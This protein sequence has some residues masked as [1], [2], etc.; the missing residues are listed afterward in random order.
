M[1]AVARRPTNSGAPSRARSGSDRPW[2]SSG[3]TTSDSRRA[4]RQRWQAGLARGGD[5]D[6]GDRAARF[7][8]AGSIV[9]GSGDPGA[10]GHHP[11][12]TVGPEDGARALVHGERGRQRR[13]RS[14]CHGDVRPLAAGRQ[15]DLDHERRGL[16]ARSPIATGDRAGGRVQ[17]ATARGDEGSFVQPRVRRCVARRPVHRA[18]GVRRR[19]PPQRDLRRPLLRRRRPPGRERELA[20]RVHR[21]SRSSRPTERGS[22]SSGPGPGSAPRGPGRSSR[23]TSTGRTSVASRHGVV[24]SWIKGGRPTASGSCTSAPTGCSRWCARMAATRMTS[25]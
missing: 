7:R 9:G 23:S 11:V 24:R 3:S 20:R 4:R 8:A 12:R 16:L 2:S 19:R 13:A 15:R 17:Q 6:R 18:R 21:R 25:P 22:R 14:R 1:N 5:H 10:D